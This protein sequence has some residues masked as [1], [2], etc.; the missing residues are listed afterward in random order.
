MGENEDI[1]L[2]YSSHVGKYYDLIGNPIPLED[3]CFMNVLKGEKVKGQKVK[4]VYDDKEYYLCFNA[5]PIFDENEQ[6]EMGVIVT[7]DIT[8]LVKNNKLI[9]SQKKELEIIFDNMYDGLV[10]IDSNGNYIKKNK[11]LNE[12]I[13]INELIYHLKYELEKL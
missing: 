11:A 5:I 6:F 8:E 12:A 3:L 4:Y 2:G 10:V 1:Y 7:H 13:N 9:S